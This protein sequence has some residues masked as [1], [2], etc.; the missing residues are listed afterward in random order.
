L[1][2]SAEVT[3]AAA[4]DEAALEHR[5]RR[6]ARRD[7]GK[8]ERDRLATAAGTGTF[9]DRPP[10]RAGA[11]G[12]RRRWGAGGARKE[13]DAA[14]NVRIAALPEG[15]GDEDAARGEA[16]DGERTGQRGRG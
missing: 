12:G 13:A 15:E 11:T 4:P 9:A 2:S 14:W 7:G 8:Q 3:V 5:R 16:C 1:A 10:L 6:L